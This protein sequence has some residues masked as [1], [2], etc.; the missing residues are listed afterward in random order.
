MAEVFDWPA[1]LNPASCNIDLQVNRK[2]FKSAFNGAVHS[3]HFPG[4]AWA[5]SLSFRDM[6]ER[7]SRLIE[8][9]IYQL[10]RGGRMRIPD[11]QRGGRN[12]VGI[13]VYGDN[14]KGN[15]LVTQGWPANTHRVLQ[16]GDYIEFN[17]EYKFVLED[18]DS[19]NAG[20]CSIR[21]SPS[22]RVAPQTGTPVNVRTPC[23]YY[24]LE[25]DKNGASRKPAFNSD[26]SL[27]F[28]E[29]FY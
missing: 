13:T 18:V 29:T 11:F 5:I 7:E 19:D 28:V 8:S 26:F 6:D 1:G 25:A 27:K 15:T 16:R 23:G 21:I 14:Q 24:V 20:R 10:E 9:C 12:Y 3:A 17:D 2:Q 4:S 22:V